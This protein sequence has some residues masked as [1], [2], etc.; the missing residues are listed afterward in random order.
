MSL[1]VPGSG[2]S[3]FQATKCAPRRETEL[4]LGPGWP[5]CRAVYGSAGDAEAGGLAAIHADTTA[6][7]RT[8]ARYI[9]ALFDG[10]HSRD[11][12]LEVVPEA[13]AIN[14]A[15]ARAPRAP[16]KSKSQKGFWPGPTCWSSR[17]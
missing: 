8:A 6:M 10:T 17:A 1:K 11:M 12:A 5:E 16:R 15:T 13:M 4:S 3:W 14:L 9:A 2:P 7:A